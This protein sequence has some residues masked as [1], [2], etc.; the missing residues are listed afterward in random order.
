MVLFV[1]VR[2]N[3]LMREDN[4][5]LVNHAYEDVLNEYNTK[6]MTEKYKQLYV[7]ELNE[8]NFEQKAILNNANVI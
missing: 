2:M 4:K 5:E 6:V 3:F 7:N 8:R 1:L